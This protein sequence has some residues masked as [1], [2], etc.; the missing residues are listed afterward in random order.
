[1]I[2]I[3]GESHSEE[4]IQAMKGQP[5]EFLVKPFKFQSLLDTAKKHRANVLQKMQTP[6]LAELVA[7]CRGVDVKALS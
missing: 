7:V 1:M 6:D 4:I 5:N 3:S 2:F